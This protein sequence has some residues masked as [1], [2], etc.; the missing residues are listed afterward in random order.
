MAFKDVT[1]LSDLNN[2]SAEEQFAREWQK[3]LSNI[4][5]PSTDS[6]RVRKITIEISIAPSTD[7]SSAKVMI[8]SK[9][10]LAPAKADENTVL[11]ELTKDGVIAMTREP[12][13]Q[14]EFDNV[15]QIERGE[16]SMDGSAVQEIKKIVNESQI[17]EVEGRKFVPHAMYE[18]ESLTKR[19]KSVEVNTLFSLV[20]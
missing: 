13:K 16:V 8:S 10:S 19:P 3:V 15:L 11:F 18:V 14:L 6:K 7:R 5:D 9:S 1:A 20:D 12:E 2:G 17:I 4:R